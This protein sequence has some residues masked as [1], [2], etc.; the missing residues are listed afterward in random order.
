MYM[1]PVLLRDLAAAHRDE[2]LRRSRR[3]LLNSPPKQRRAGFR[4]RRDRA[5]PFAV[6]RPRLGRV[7]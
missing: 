2:Q 7:L 3:L 4:Y 5:G 1:H 6:L